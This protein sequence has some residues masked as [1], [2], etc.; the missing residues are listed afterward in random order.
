M[1]IKN[2]IKGL[3]A[4]PKTT[5]IGFVYR[6]WPHVVPER[7]Y[8]E[9]AYKISMGKELHLNNPVLFTEKLQWMKLYYHHP[10]LTKLVDKYE[11]KKYV[12]E[13]LGDEVVLPCYGV[14]NSFDEID[15]AG[16]PNQFILKCTHDSGVFFVCEDKNTFDKESAR[17]KLTKHLQHDQFMDSH[18]WAY[19]NVKPRIIAEKYEPSLGKQ[20]SVEYKLT[21]CDGEVKC[22]T[23][24]TGIPHADYELRHNDNFNK[25]WTRQHW[26]AFYKPLGGDIPKPKEMDMMIAYSEKLSKEIPQVRIDWYLING[27]VVF[28][29]FT[30]Y[31]WGGLIKFEPESQDRV[32]GDWI[33]LPHKMR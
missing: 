6:R 20:D 17:V 16:L 9:W 11:V 2:R 5:L 19:K 23:V 22:I 12:K 7:L 3:I 4:D 32:M 26:Y 33:K 18:E 29:E 28:G 15:F 1:S 10:L 30:F 24:C 13:R 14:W 31:T 21:C 27:K 8:L 25:D